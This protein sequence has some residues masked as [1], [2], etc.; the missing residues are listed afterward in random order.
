MPTVTPIVDLICEGAT[1][2][3]AVWS[4]AAPEPPAVV[5]VTFGDVLVL[6]DEDDAPEHAARV[7]DRTT[8]ATT[9]PA[10]R[11]LRTSRGIGAP[12]T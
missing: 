5:V 1:S 9:A 4:S 10:E 8:N 12:Y 6:L 3:H 7:T 11:N 2:A